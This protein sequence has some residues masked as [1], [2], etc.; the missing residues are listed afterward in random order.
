MP[1]VTSAD[2]TAIAYERSGSGPAIVLVDGALC[3]RAG[4]PMRPLAAALAGDFTV[5]AYDRRGRG[6]SGDTQPYALQ[7]EV[8]D[9]RAV[10]DVAAAAGGSVALYGISS[11]AALSLHTAAV[12]AR[13]SAMVLYE[14]PYVASAN[15]AIAT[16]EYRTA[17]D[18]ALA[19][20]RRGDAVALF[21]E[22]VG[23]PAPMVD[24]MRSGPGWPAMEAIAPTLAYDDTVI[25]G[26]RVPYEQAKTVDVPVLVLAGDASPQIMREAA[27][28]AAGA[29]PHGSY[30]TLA[31]Q[32]HDIAAQAIAPA[33]TEFLRS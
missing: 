2:G 13:I 15:P 27:E 8:D 14:P 9:L 1:T 20:G 29:L 12:D 25:T 11:G 31:D 23:V 10:V 32:T 4:G 7:R 22:Q 3:H 21:L 5:Y 28:A 18:A 30:G 6:D 17:L 24:G 26:G 16:G 33:I 19:A